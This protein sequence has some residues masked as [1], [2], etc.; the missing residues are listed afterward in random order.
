MIITFINKMKNTCNLPLLLI[1][2]IIICSFACSVRSDKANFQITD[3][4]WKRE[5]LSYF[6]FYSGGI[7]EAWIHNQINVSFD[8]NLLVFK[9]ISD[10][11]RFCDSYSSS[12]AC[13]NLLSILPCTFLF[14]TTENGSLSIN[15]TITEKDFYFLVLLNCNG[16]Q[17]DTQFSYVFVNPHGEYLGYNCIPYKYFYGIFLGLWII[18]IILWV[19]N[20][21]IN[22]TRKFSI[23]HRIITT[24]PILK[25]IWLT[26]AF[27]TW[28][29]LSVNGTYPTAASVLYYFI[30]ILQ[31]VALY[32]VFLFISLGYG[33]VI[34]NLGYNWMLW[35]SL[36][37][38]LAAAMSFGL[39]SGSLFELVV[40]I[41]YVII[42][43]FIFHNSRI[44]LLLLQKV[45]DDPNDTN[46]PRVENASEK[47]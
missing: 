14:R 47:N 29:G 2:I 18:F 22:R 16:S 9:S 1:T 4:R 35:V 27:G 26:Y 31:R 41:A 38:A 36:L 3:N 30:F 13:Q 5:T 34:L 10:Y 17:T 28:L 43:I 32:G 20:W 6:A 7:M 37:L 11:N 44:T 25:I 15:I 33:I 23:L 19:I 45:R 46:L 8:L 21:V 40:L 12:L 24:Y 42:M 39:A